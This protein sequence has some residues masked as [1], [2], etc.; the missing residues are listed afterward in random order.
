MLGESASTCRRQIGHS[1]GPFMDRVR[2]GQRLKDRRIAL[3]LTLREAAP[4]CGV[5][6]QS[7]G[8]VERGTKNATMD[9]LDKIATGLGITLDLVVSEEKPL[10][11]DRDAL[12]AR[13]QRVAPLIPG[14]ELDIFVAELALWERR[15]GKK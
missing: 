13:F 6:F 15:Y 12:I 9:L 11:N 3:G 2:I 8:A 10:P 14:E 5:S 1:T 4:I 7:L